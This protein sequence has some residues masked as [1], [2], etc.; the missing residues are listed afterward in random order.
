M[1]VGGAGV[2]QDGARL[3]GALVEGAFAGRTDLQ[4]VGGGLISLA[5]E[6]LSEQF[7]A[8]LSADEYG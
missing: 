7:S 5:L 3:R 4:R 6:G 1:P 2:A 8:K